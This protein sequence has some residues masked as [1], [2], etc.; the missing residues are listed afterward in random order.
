MSHNRAVTRVNFS[1]NVKSTTS[2][3]VSGSSGA[4]HLVLSSS[5]DGTARMW[6]GSKVDGSII[7]FSHERCSSSSSILH[8]SS[9]RVSNG[10][11]NTANNNVAIAAE[12]TTNRRNRPYVGPV[13][14]ASFYYNDKFVVL[15]NTNAVYLYNYQCE[16]IHAGND[17]KSYA[18]AS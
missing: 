4:K 11:G 6:R 15:G 8:S 9:S 10:I 7:E 3:G 2:R 16:S 14:D 12:T 13:I 18:V 5:E 1:H 17:L